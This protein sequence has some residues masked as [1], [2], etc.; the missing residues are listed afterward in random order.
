MK[1][2]IIPSDGTNAEQRTDVGINNVN[3]FFAKPHVGSRQVR[4]FKVE[5]STK[6]G[7]Q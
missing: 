6:T 5:R 4:K 3:P 7:K 2:N 1:Q